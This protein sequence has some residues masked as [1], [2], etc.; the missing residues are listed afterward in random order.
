MHYSKYHILA[1]TRI[2][3]I[4]IVKNV[5]R[6]G[7]VRIEKLFNIYRRRRKFEEGKVR[8][9]VKITQKPSRTFLSSVSFPKLGLPPKLPAEL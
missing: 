9:C 3:V 7:E 2:Q 8:K 1:C 6:R 4:G 5:V